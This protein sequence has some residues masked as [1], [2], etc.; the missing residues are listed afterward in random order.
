M[1]LRGPV[2]KHSQFCGPRGTVDYARELLSRESDPKVI[3]SVFY[4]ES[5]GGQ[6][7]A[8]K[9]I[10]DVMQ[11]IKK[12]LVVLG[13]SVVASAAYYIAAFAR[14]IVVEHPRS[15][16]GSIGTMLAY[17]DIQPALEK[18]GVAFHDIYATRSK[19]K[20]LNYLELN[21]VNTGPITNGWHE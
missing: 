10:T 17:Q 19:R 2:M 11:R 20:N 18:L 1:R 12:P 6:S 13:G 15:V 16:I 14:E 9:P 3:G 7:Y 5:G 21:K 4:I 8:V